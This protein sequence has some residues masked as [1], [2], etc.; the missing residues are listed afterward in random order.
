[1]PICR[2]KIV[3]SSGWLWLRLAVGLQAASF[4]YDIGGA[5]TAKWCSAV[6]L[7]FDKA[8]ATTGGY[9][10]SAAELSLV[11][12]DGC[13]ALAMA[14]FAAAQHGLQSSNSRGVGMASSVRQGWFFLIIA[15]RVQIVTASKRGR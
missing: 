7:R 3:Q 5:I 8:V 6:E 1:M 4:N 12:L 11:A 14:V 15:Q 13:R 2:L 9:E 10:S